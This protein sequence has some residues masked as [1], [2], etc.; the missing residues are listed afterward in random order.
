MWHVGHL[1]KSTESDY[2]SVAGR[3]KVEKVKKMVLFVRVIE[4]REFGRSNNGEISDFK[5][6]VSN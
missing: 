3:V 1:S 6:I 5:A 2:P 4:L